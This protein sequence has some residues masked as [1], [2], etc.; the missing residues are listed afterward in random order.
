VLLVVNDDDEGGDEESL[1]AYHSEQVFHIARRR[2]KRY[3]KQSV[4]LGSVPHAAGSWGINSIGKKLYKN[5]VT[6]LSMKQQ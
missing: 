3:Y 5:A 6:V 1:I 2:Y 4:F